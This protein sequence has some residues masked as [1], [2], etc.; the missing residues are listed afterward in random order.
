M[1]NPF[2][3]TAATN[4]ITLDNRR[5]GVAAFTVRNLTRRRVRAVS[6][7]LT[8]PPDSPASE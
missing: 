2:E 4:T 6:R 8:T 5:E 7:L 1:A 3:I